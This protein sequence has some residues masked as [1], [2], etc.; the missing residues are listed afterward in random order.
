MLFHRQRLAT[1]ISL[2]TCVGLKGLTGTT[3]SS[4]SSDPRKEKIFPRRR[5]LDSNAFWLTHVFRI[6]SV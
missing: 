4:L 3:S 6:E 1:Q 2:A 5:L